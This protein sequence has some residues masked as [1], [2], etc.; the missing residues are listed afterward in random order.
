MSA[1]IRGSRAVSV[2]AVGVPVVL[3][4]DQAA[5]VGAVEEEALAGLALT[6]RDAAVRA[7]GH[8]ALALRAGHLV[9]V[10]HGTPP[11]RRT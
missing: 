5:E 4:L 8:R 10:S 11:G 2:G 7:L 1:V 3:G 9:H 6:D